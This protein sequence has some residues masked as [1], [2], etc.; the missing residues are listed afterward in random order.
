LPP[1]ALI[2]TASFGEGPDLPARNL[3]EPL[4]EEGPGVVR[5]SALQILATV[6]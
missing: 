2:I 3:A 5:S 4:R 1:R 6:P